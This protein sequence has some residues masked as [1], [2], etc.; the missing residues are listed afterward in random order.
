MKVLTP[1]FKI[2]SPRLWTTELTTQ[3]LFI[4]YMTYIHDTE[5]DSR[6]EQRREMES[7]VTSLYVTTPKLHAVI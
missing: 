3:Q 7:D 5:T 1:G 2:P 6:V 4:R